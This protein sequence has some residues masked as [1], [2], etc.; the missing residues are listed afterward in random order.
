MSEYCDQSTGKVSGY[1]R[2]LLRVYT[3][4]VDNNVAVLSLSHALA[5][6][7]AARGSLGLPSLRGQ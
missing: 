6:S 1:A 4:V 2:T 3:L 7:A 5:T